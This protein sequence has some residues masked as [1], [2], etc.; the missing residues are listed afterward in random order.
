MTEHVLDWK[1][2]FSPKSLNYRINDIPGE[3]RTRNS[4]WKRDLWLNQGPTS[5]CTGF[6]L[7]HV[8]GTTP[9]R[10]KG[11]TF[12]FATERYNRARQCDEWAGEDYDG[13]SVL[14]AM[15]AAKADGLIS[16][17]HWATTLIEIQ[18]ALSYLG[19]MEI[20]VNWY[21]G[22]FETDANGFVRTTGQVEGGHAVCLGGISMARGGCL[23]YNSWGKDWGVKGNAWISFEDVQKLM[24]EWGEF[25]LPKKV[26]A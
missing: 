21:T 9:K 1:R 23:I 12:D 18:H 20:G 15:E 4:I 10:K 19:P 14:G 6:G 13:S 17:Y 11:L 2:R 5:G 24:S 7:T 3:L 8:L 22:M 25:A 16:S 26:K